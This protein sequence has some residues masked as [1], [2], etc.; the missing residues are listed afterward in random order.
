MLVLMQFGKRAVRKNARQRA[1]VNIAVPLQDVRVIMVQPC[2]PDLPYKTISAHDIE[3]INE[4]LIDLFIF[5]QRAMHC[6]MHEVQKDHHQHQSHYEV[7]A[8]AHP[9]I[10]SPNEG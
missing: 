6:V 7:C 5:K 2:M 1:L 8:I 4:T 9:G 10:T 3:K